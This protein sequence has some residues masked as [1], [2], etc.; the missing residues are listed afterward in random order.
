[1]TKKASHVIR[2][3]PPLLNSALFC[4]YPICQMPGGL[5]KAKCS[6]CSQIVYLSIMAI[7]V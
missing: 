5:R 1:M 7:K 4:G 3:S 2:R 6:V